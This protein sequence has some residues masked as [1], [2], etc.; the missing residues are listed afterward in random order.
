MNNDDI[1]RVSFFGRIKSI[2]SSF[3]TTERTVF[4]LFAI[5]FIV[6]SLFILNAISQNYMTEVPVDGGTLEE[7]VVG[8]PSTINPVLA[9]TDTDK[10]L[11]ELI[12][13]GLLKATPTGVIPDLA[14]KIDVSED[15]LTYDVTIRADAVFQDNTPVTA[16]DVMFTV[17]KVQSP[18]INSP[19][20][21]NWS[22]IEMQKVN[23]KEVK[24]ILKKIYPGF[25]E[26]LTL[27]ILPKHMWDAID[28][29]L[30]AHSLNN[31]EP[32]GSGPYTIKSSSKNSGGIYEF[33][34]LVP[35]D[36]YTGGKG[37]IAHII[38]RFFKNEESAV[39]AYLHGNIN[40]LGGISPNSAKKLEASGATIKAIPL[41]RTFAIFFNQ[42]HAPILLNQEVRQ[43]F[44]LSIDRAE[45]INSSLQGYG[46]LATSPLPARF[47]TEDLFPVGT[48]TPSNDI[49]AAKKLLSDNG[50]KANADGIL[51]K[52]TADAKKKTSTT[53]TLH[54]K[55]ATS[56]I[57]ELKQTAEIIAKEWRAIGASVDVEIFEPSDLTQKVIAT[58]KFDALL[59]GNAKGRDLDLY[60]FWHSSQRNYPGLNI[61]GYANVKADKFL[62]QARETSSS[63]LRDIAY[64]GFV[65]ELL[66]DTPAAF[67]YSPQY[68]YA[69]PRNI[70]NVS[71]AEMTT[72]SER[73]MS[74]SQW[75]IETEKI[76]N[77]FIS[78]KQE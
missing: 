25:T 16:D 2:I 57:P 74:V 68:I 27:G 39:D 70:L 62:E 43:A 23:D 34:D 17:G 44:D 67:L 19:K 76:W 4:V 11:T 31:Q 61:A 59:F 18:V 71:I 29:S 28:P 37:H 8:F 64:Q 1:S 54:I 26:N 13:S 73:F 6:S 3:G 75:Y 47:G 77:F 14:S 78:K 22:G 69:V 33:Y 58:R 48:S 9:Y 12:Y 35:F 72:P 63:T 20:Q 32:I 40:S 36:K 60:P 15:G 7:G 41:P 66:N 46:I 30:F 5:L 53:L 38:A 50:W 24:F 51:E 42:S 49:E 45:L 65:K 52:K 56:N 55:L 10:D 21:S